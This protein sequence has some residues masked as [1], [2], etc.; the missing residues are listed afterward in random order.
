MTVF[1]I[2][3][4]R[5]TNPLS[6]TRQYKLEPI[7]VSSVETLGVN[8]EQEIYCANIEEKSIAFVCG[9]GRAHTITFGRIVR[10]GRP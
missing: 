6:E 8:H 1:A 9:N 10:A 2:T 5:A 3:I 7:N 4:E